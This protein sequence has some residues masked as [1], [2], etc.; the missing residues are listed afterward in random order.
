[1]NLIQGKIEKIN[2][3]SGEKYFIIIDKIN[4]SYKI[5]FYGYIPIERF[6]FIKC[7][8]EKKQNGE[9]YL[10]D[11]PNIIMGTELSIIRFIF[12]NVLDETGE[13][14]KGKETWKEIRKKINYLMSKTNNKIFEHLNYSSSNYPVLI[15]SYLPDIFDQK[16]ICLFSKIWEK[17]RNMRALYLLGL[18]KKEIKNS[19]Y[20]TID[21]YNKLIENPYKIIE[22]DMIKANKTC[23]MLNLEFNNE[24]KQIGE[25]ARYVYNKTKNNNY[26]SISVKKL[27]ILFGDIFNKE[28]IEEY[29]IKNENDFIFCNTVLNEEIEVSNEFK[30]L[31]ENEKF[32][33]LYDPID[34]EYLNYYCQQNN[35]KLSP[36]Q[37]DALLNIFI[38]PVT[39]ITGSAGTGKTT[40]ISTL[41]SY[42]KYKNYSYKASS[43][44]GKAVSRIEEVISDTENCSTIHRLLKFNCL[45]DQILIIDEATMISLQLFHRIF[46]ILGNDITKLILVGDVNQ[47]ESIRYGT[48]FK[49]L[50]E[51]KRIPTF[52]LIN[53]HRTVSNNNEDG[54]IKNS[55]QIIKHINGDFHFF[56][57]NNFVLKEGDEKTLLDNIEFF[58]KNVNKKDIK[59]ITPYK[60]YVNMFNNYVQSLTTENN[61]TSGFKEVK[62]YNGNIFKIGDIV[63]CLKNNYEN[64]VFNGQEGIIKKFE[65]DENNKTLVKIKLFNNNRKILVP[66]NPLSNNKYSLNIEERQD[67]DY[68]DDILEDDEEDDIEFC[69]DRFSLSYALTTDKSQGSEWDIIIIFFPLK[70]NNSFLNKNRL[71]T[72][73]TRAKKLCV[74]FGNK[75]LYRNI[76]NNKTIPK[77][78]KIKERLEKILNTTYNVQQI[79]NEIDIDPNEYYDEIDEFYY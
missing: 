3:Y 58:Y 70:S 28:E 46:T 29:G 15:N 44:T 61:T 13:G 68:F 22:I 26:T 78:E 12:K 24:V 57:T 35:I 8:C 10:V 56:E 11:K 27:S 1:M 73:I 43:Y 66:L 59:I 62:T 53:S 76:I 63:M 65:K 5:L 42:F 17:K 49:N 54:I 36:D 20:N 41:I 7:K 37:R 67:N 75:Q 55:N 18:S 48:V 64:Y 31:I 77:G 2:Y 21:L 39:I 34:D 51:S 23:E 14:N 30:K 33:N 71:Y 45:N 79:E 47:L 25:A 6:D 9:F 60:Q 50:I 38:K 4:K 74:C 16:Q 40:L 69:M 72:S 52:Y 19:S 32:Q